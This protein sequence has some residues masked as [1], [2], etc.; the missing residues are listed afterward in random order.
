VFWG[1]PTGKVV[2][3]LAGLL[4]VTRTGVGPKWVR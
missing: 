3:V 2:A 1:Q 4:L